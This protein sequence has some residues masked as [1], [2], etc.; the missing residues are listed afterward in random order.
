MLIGWGED[1]YRILIVLLYAGK[2]KELD[3]IN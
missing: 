3:R 1:G 2:S